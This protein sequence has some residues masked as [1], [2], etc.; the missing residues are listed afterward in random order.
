MDRREFL[1]AAGGTILAVGAWGWGV[2]SLT[3]TN[4]PL[5]NGGFRKDLD[6]IRQ[7]VT[8]AQGVS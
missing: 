8:A 3:Y 7:F 1:T 5:P 4:H 6:R 2:D